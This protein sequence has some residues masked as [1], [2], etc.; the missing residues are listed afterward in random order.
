MDPELTGPSIL[1]GIDFSECSERALLHAV[2]LAERRQAQL[3]LI[4]VFE[5]HQAS[6]SED[7]PPPAAGSGLWREVTALAQAARRRLSHLCTTFVADRVPAE[8]RV[9]IGNPTTEML[10]TAEQSAASLIVLGATGRSIMPRGE[11]GTM[12]KSV[13]AG[14]AIP[15]LLVP[16]GEAKQQR[17]G[18]LFLLSAHD[19]MLWTCTRCGTLQRVGGSAGKCG[20]C[21]G[22]LTTS[23]AIAPP[24]LTPLALGN[25]RVGWE[26]QELDD[27]PKSAAA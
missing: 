20:F 25:A 10:K 7:A 21:D 2:T 11:L 17:P 22:A 16:L 24:R 14:S 27:N 18:H 3:E 6:E 19:H 4:H 13:C 9:L 26:V 8:V 23:F 5:W 1:V 12:A 15:V